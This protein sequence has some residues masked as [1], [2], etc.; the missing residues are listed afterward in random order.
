MEKKDDY[1][2]ECNTHVKADLRISGSLN[3]KHRRNP[4]KSISYDSS[5]GRLGQPFLHSSLFCK[6]VSEASK[7][8]SS[9]VD[10]CQM[11][12]SCVLVVHD[13]YLPPFC[14]TVSTLAVLCYLLVSERILCHPTRK[15]LERIAIVVSK[16]VLFH[17][18]VFQ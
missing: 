18:G 8:S 4:R 13:I 10:I 11:H 6:I 12:I 9:S 1:S 2:K 16:V 5:Y 7:Y 14:H 17:S 15:K 3:G